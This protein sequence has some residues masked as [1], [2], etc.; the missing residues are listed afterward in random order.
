MA[1]NPYTLANLCDKGILNSADIA[2]L[3]APTVP[4]MPVGNQYLNMAMQG[5]LYRN[6]G[7]SNDSFHSGYT[8]AYTATYPQ[9]MPA[10]GYSGIPAE[11]GSR[12]NVGGFNAFNGYGVGI[13]NNNNLLKN[14]GEDGVTGS[15]CVNGGLNAFGGFSDTQNNI[16]SGFNKTASLFGRIPK[17]VWGLVAGII[18]VTGIVLAIKRGKK[19]VEM[20]KEDSNFFSKLKFWKKK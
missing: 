3:N 18:G 6:Y 2:M 14:F 17:E 8:P 4:F 20:V 15:Q 16:S 10:G 1:I 19:P 9:G 5:N 12:S 11:I 13:Y 7:M